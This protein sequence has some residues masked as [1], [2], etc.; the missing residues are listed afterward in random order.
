MNKS[1]V[2]YNS[3]MPSV[4]AFPAETVLFY[5]SVLAKNKKL[6]AWLKSFPYQIA[7]Q[8]GEKL[9][10][11]DFKAVRQDLQGTKA[12]FLFPVLKVGDECSAQ[13]GVNGEIR[14]RPAAS[15]TQV[16]NATA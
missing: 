16:A 13:T 3:Q 6:K 14:L 4:R 12:R 2:I 11:R 1:Q 5:D 10:K 15:S 7:L 8:S 9:R